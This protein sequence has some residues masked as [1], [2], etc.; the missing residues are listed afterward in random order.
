MDRLTGFRV[1]TEA[2]ERGSIAAA[3]R[4]L[5]MTPAMAG[6][7]LAAL[8]TNLRTRLLH[9]TT[10]RLHPTE[11]GDLYYKRVRA[12]LN[13]VD[14][15]DRAARDAD[16]EPSG[17]LRI[18][19]PPTFATH[20]L[21]PFLAAFALRYPRV[22]ID[23]TAENR[24]TDLVAGGFDLAIRIGEMAESSLV[25]RRVGTCRLIACAS[26]AYLDRRFR[27]ATAEQLRDFDRLVFAG[28]TSPGDWRFVDPDGRATTIENEA[29]VRLRADSVDVLVKAAV[30]GA[31]IAFGP[32]FAFAASLHRGVLERILPDHATTAL[33][34]HVVYPSRRHV[35]TH[36]R[37]FID[38]LA[39]QLRR[40]P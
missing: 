2:V 15:A 8:E 30:S 6:K 32:D 11:A 13:A 14:E 24:L 16:G 21:G 27:P 29:G 19:A 12:I 33:D 36:V 3:A 5:G 9:R 26:P 38:M 40:D 20:R 31:G 18:A 34:I 23:M 4:I 28:A 39:E 7:H 22:R 25:A 37:C 35:G 10:R 17:T 1:F